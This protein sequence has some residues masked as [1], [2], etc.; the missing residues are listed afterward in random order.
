MYTY[1]ILSNNYIY[2]L[3]EFL[4][5]D[6][7]TVAIGTVVTRRRSYCNQTGRVLTRA[8][9]LLGETTHVSSAQFR[10]LKLRCAQGSGELF[11]LKC[12][13]RDGLEFQAQCVE[14]SEVIFEFEKY[15]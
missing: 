15:L 5:K 3:S 1:Y 12:G 13:R 9:R 4:N 14:V 10:Q 6:T 8:D 11:V 2:I 7:L